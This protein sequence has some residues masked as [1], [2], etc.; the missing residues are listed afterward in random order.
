MY[1]DDGMIMGY[2]I[3][4]LVYG[5][6]FAWASAAVAKGKGK[7]AGV[8]GVVGF[9]LGIIGLLI[10]AVLPEE[11]DFTN[12][13]GSSQGARTTAKSDDSIRFIAS[14]PAKL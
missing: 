11:A 4:Y 2:L 10:I 1:Y 9:L 7:D 3:G 12:S 14:I 13:K 5:G 6:I 8:W